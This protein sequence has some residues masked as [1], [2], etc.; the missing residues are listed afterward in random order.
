[1]LRRPFSRSAFTCLVLS[2]AA[3]VA[4]Q[5]PPA[6]QQKALAL[7]DALEA[8]VPGVAR[9]LIWLR[10]SVKRAPRMPV[11]SLEGLMAIDAA[12]ARAGELPPPD[13]EKLVASAEAD[14][15]LKAEYCRMHPDGMAALVNLVV[16]TWAQAGDTRSEV[17]QWDVRY[18]SAPMAVFP[19]RKGE[20]F[21]GFSSPAAKP[22]SPGRYV[23]WAQDPANPSRRGPEKEVTVGDSATPI[24]Q[25]RADIL[26]VTR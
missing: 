12:L 16:H 4:G 13:R 21:P 6:E 14:V 5:A 17:S 18:L 24:E 26:V 9:E 10:A 7:I 2:F 23:I 19:G 15:R 1:M 11:E 20:Q 8:K 22:L 25:V 3:S